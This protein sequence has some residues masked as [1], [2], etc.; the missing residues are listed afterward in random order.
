MNRQAFS[1]SALISESDESS[2]D[3]DSLIETNEIGIILFILFFD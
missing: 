3:G 2:I 1:I